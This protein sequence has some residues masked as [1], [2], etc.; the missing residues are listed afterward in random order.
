MSIRPNVHSG[1]CR[2]RE[3]FFWKVYV[4]GN[5]FRG[6]VRIPVK[7]MNWLFDMLHALLHHRGRTNLSSNSGN[8][9]L[10]ISS[11]QTEDA[12]RYMCDVRVGVDRSTAF[13]T[14]NV[15]QSKT[16]NF[17]STILYRLGILHSSIYAVMIE[18][19]SPCFFKELDKIYIFFR[20]C[21]QKTA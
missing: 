20:K 10:T 14:L 16:V 15:K 1:K 21:G 17:F 6:G 18:P 9:S 2:F 5:V 4:Q 12:G 19:V 7:S 8:A 13:V 3:M 11:V